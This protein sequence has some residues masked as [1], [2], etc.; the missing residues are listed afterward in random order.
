MQFVRIKMLPISKQ[1][2][3]TCFQFDCPISN[4]ITGQTRDLLLT[5]P[6]VDSD[7]KQTEYVDY[8]MSFFNDAHQNLYFSSHDLTSS[9]APTPNSNFVV[10]TSLSVPL[11]VNNI[12]VP[13]LILGDLSQFKS[14]NI[15]LTL[16]TRQNQLHVGTRF[17]ARGLNQLAGAANEYEHQFI[18][19][20]DKIVFGYTFLRGSAPINWKSDANLIKNDFIIDSEQNTSH[21]YWARALDQYNECYVLNLL[22]RSETGSKIGSNASFDATEDSK[23]DET[24]LCAAYANSIPKVNEYLKQY[25]K[26]IKYTNFQWHEEVHKAKHVVKEWIKE[27][28]KNANIKQFGVQLDGSKKIAM[29]RED[30]TYTGQMLTLVKLLQQLHLEQFDITMGVMTNTKLPQII[31]KQQKIMRVN[32]AD[33][34]DRTNLVLFH[35]SQVFNTIIIR[36]INENTDSI[37]QFVHNHEFDLQAEFLLFQSMILKQFK[38]QKETQEIRL[39]YLSLLE[40]MLFTEAPGLMYNE[41][42]QVFFKIANTLSNIYAGTNAAHQEIISLFCDLQVANNNMVA[43]KR[44]VQSVGKGE[45]KKNDIKNCLSIDNSAQIVSIKPFGIQ[46]DSQYCDIEFL[47]TQNYL[48][49]I[50]LTQNKFDGYPA[51]QEQASFQLMKSANIYQQSLSE[52]FALA[53]AKYQ[54]L[55]KIIFDHGLTKIFTNFYTVKKLQLTNIIDMNYFDQLFQIQLNQADYFK[56]MM[57]LQIIEPK[58][59]HFYSTPG[60]SEIDPIQMLYRQN[61][62]QLTRSI[63]NVDENNRIREVLKIQV[64]HDFC[65]INLLDTVQLLE[66][67][68][69]FYSRQFGSDLKQIQSNNESKVFHLKYDFDSNIS[70]TDLIVTIP[71]TYLNCAS[72]QLILIAKDDTGSDFIIDIFSLPESVIQEQIVYFKLQ[73]FNPQTESQMISNIYTTNSI[74]DNMRFTSASNYPKIKQLIILFKISNLSGCLPKL[75]VFGIPR[76]TQT[77]INDAGYKSFNNTVIQMI[78]TSVSEKLNK[79]ETDNLTYPL[80]SLLT[81]FKHSHKDETSII[82]YMFTKTFEMERTPH[83][84]KTFSDAFIISAFIFK[85]KVQQHYAFSIFRLLNISQSYIQRIINPL[86]QFDK[87][88]DGF[89]S[90]Q[91]LASDQKIVKPNFE[92][93]LMNQSY[94]EKVV[95]PEGLCDQCAKKDILLKCGCCRALFCKNCLN[96]ETISISYQFEFSKICIVCKPC[97]AQQFQI[98]TMLSKYYQYILDSAQ[99][100]PLVS[101]QH[102][103]KENQLTFK[104]N[105]YESAILQISNRMTILSFYINNTKYEFIAT[106]SRFYQQI[107]LKQNV[108]SQSIVINFNLAPRQSEI[109]MQVTNHRFLLPFINLKALQAQSKCQ[110]YQKIECFDS[111]ITQIQNNIIVYDYVFKDRIQIQKIQFN[112]LTNKPIRIQISYLAP[113]EDDE[114]IQQ[115]KKPTKFI[116]AKQNVNCQRITQEQI[117]L[118]DGFV[119]GKLVSFQT[120]CQYQSNRVQIVME[121][122]DEVNDLALELFI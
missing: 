58:Q 99:I 69:E 38:P 85:S 26:N 49:L 79:I 80:L 56:R 72:K 120:T 106:K 43:I 64:Q 48:Q 36:F 84:T 105:S 55:S 115:K 3:S 87:N 103:I 108:Q 94:V 8:V 119:G 96:Q 117:E 14:N 57:G 107:E 17:N 33:S 39:F 53:D 30:S 74:F 95:S 83:I 13:K 9:F 1:L 37:N 100:I 45:V 31:H 77:I 25:A 7:Y 70:I 50:Y 22:R 10:N 81:C 19:E 40:Q 88:I 90:I 52:K 6:N 122:K 28:G 82:D 101:V 20:T 109:K 47:T 113:H 41:I 89:P 97:Y 27:G 12:S 51:T 2:Q 4:T 61:I 102:Q 5:S 32:C 118:F 23:T 59:Q 111:N 15:K 116:K 76:Q 112:N 86:V 78:S 93:A 121:Y 73:Q 44:R 21:I 11:L 71:T 67:E 104:L 46:L 35:L 91:I 42:A 54:Q 110:Q 65:P 98:Q 62:G 75:Q 34:L 114:Y 24:A 16:I 92:Q 66:N 68:I 29:F 63:S 60:F 18:Y